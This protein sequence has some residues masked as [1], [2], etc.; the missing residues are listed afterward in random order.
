MQ[1]NGMLIKHLM[2]IYR[3]LVLTI[4]ETCGISGCQEQSACKRFP[5]I[6]ALPPDFA[7]YRKIS[8]LPQL[9]VRMP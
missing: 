9:G 6:V 1:I 3:C 8:S 2:S 7:V 4:L 5:N